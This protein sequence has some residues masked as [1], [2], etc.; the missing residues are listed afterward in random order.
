MKFMTPAQRDLIKL[1]IAMAK[2]HSPGPFEGIDEAIAA[3]E[4]LVN[5]QDEGDHD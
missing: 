1:Y 3:L 2:K 5:E 4:E